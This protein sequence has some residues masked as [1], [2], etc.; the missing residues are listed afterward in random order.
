MRFRPTAVGYL[1]SDVSGIRQ[2][3]DEEQI[4]SRARRLGYDFAKLVVADGRS[5]RHLTAALKS[6][7][8]RLDAEAVIVPD[9]THFEGHVIPD[10]LVKAADV[11]T[12]DPDE[13]Y[14]RW[15]IPPIPDNPA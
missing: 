11:I 2:A 6:A 9:A 7:I 13:T 8:T 5:G 1:R 14:A 3:W 4:R 12:V 10:D 15:G